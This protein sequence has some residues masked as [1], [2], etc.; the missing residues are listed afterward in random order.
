[1][2]TSAHTSS[3]NIISTIDVLCFFSQIDVVCLRERLECHWGHFDTLEVII[4]V[5]DILNAFCLHLVPHVVLPDV[6]CTPPIHLRCVQLQ[7]R[8]SS[9]NVARRPGSAG[10]VTGRR[11][12]SRDNTGQIYAVHAEHS[13]LPLVEWQAKS[14]PCNLSR[15]IVV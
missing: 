3:S 11:D 1:M 14:L 4:F 10:S 7:Y 5:F 12:R 2:T 15:E 9:T 13:K 6:G 8:C